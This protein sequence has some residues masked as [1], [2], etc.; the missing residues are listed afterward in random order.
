VGVALLAAMAVVAAKSMK[1]D[2][3]DTIDI[4]PTATNTSPSNN[5][6]QPLI[7]ASDTVTPTPPESTSATPDAAPTPTTPTSKPTGTGTKP[8][9]SATADAGKPASGGDAACDACI[10]AA[11]ARNIPGAKSN[12]DRCGDAAQ[13]QLCTKEASRNAPDIV[14]S[15]A[16]QGNCGAATVVINAGKAM[17]IPGA[18]LEK[19]LKGSSCKP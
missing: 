8:P 2:S 12:F 10:A 18:R 14:N 1:G 15:L 6:I 4:G 16:L 7:D 5:V 19:G 17:G 11:K 9:A 13:K 3:N